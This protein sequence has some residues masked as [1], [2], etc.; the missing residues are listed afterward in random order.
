MVRAAPRRA[1]PLSDFACRRARYVRQTACVVAAV[2]LLSI[3]LACAVVAIVV[4]ARG[5]DAGASTTLPG[6]GLAPLSASL[7]A[8]QGTAENSLVWETL[9]Q[10]AEGGGTSRLSVAPWTG[11]VTVPAGRYLPATA[12]FARALQ[13]LVRSRIGAGSSITT[14]SEGAGLLFRFDAS[15]ELLSGLS[16]GLFEVM[17]ASRGGFL[18]PVRLVGSKQVVGHGAYVPAGG[19]AVGA[20][21][22]AAAAPALAPVLLVA[23][24]TAALEFAAAAEQRRQLE[25][26]TKITAAVREEQVRQQIA[27]LE[28]AARSLE[29]AAGSVVDV[30]FVPKALGID[31]AADTVGREWQRSSRK[32][33]E[34]RDA[35]AKL[36]ESATV[37]S[38]AEAFPGFMLPDGGEFWRELAIYRMTHALHL[39]A[40][41]LAAAEAAAHSPENAYPAFQNRLQVHARELE[42]GRDSLRAFV[43][44]LASCEIR[45]GRVV[46]RGMANQVLAVTRRLLALAS[47]LTHPVPEAD[48][49]AAIGP[50][51]TVELE[52][53]LQPDGSLT[54]LPSDDTG[55]EELGQ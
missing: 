10:P 53:V 36:G 44:D 28:A 22:T 45:V 29:L 33:Q 23:G 20:G 5:R 12:P 34:W 13:E 38:L 15:P 2:V 43:S 51:G 25:A 35:L 6:A 32:L 7:P 54:L 3:A 55:A 17:P 18:S 27:G 4:L 26:I 46:T 39:R 31:S 50:G 37:D 24:I 48:L 30:G 21:A 49:P 16:R 14:L 47:E 1:T 11:P 19:T 41:L 8:P 42:E 9:L 40:T 52:G